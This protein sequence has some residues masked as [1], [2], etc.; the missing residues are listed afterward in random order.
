MTS[1]G[2]IGLLFSLGLGAV[3]AMSCQAPA[4]A[5]AA[6]AKPAP[7]ATPTAQPVPEKKVEAPKPK[8]ARRLLMGS[9][10]TTSSYYAYHVAEG[11]VLNAN[12]PALNVTV[13]ESA[14]GKDN[15]ERM[16]K[17]EIH[18]GLLNGVQAYQAYNGIED[19]KD[20][21]RPDLRYLW[22]YS[23]GARAY[24]VRED[25]GVKTLQ[26]LEG[27]PFNPGLLGSGVD[28]ETKLAF[29]VLGIKPKWYEGRD[30]DTVTAIKNREIVGYVK[31]QAA[32]K[33][34]A[35]TMDLKTFTP[36]RV[37][38]FTPEQVNK[39]KEK[40]PYMSFIKIEAGR[41]YA[42]S[43]EWTGSVVAVGTG[44]MKGVFSDEEAYAMFK[45]VDKNVEQM[46]VAFPAV[47][48]EDYGKLTV[49]TSPIPLHPGS[50]KYLR[51]RGLTVK[52]EL[53]PPEAK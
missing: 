27:K 47:K 36:I 4:A 24:I 3:V 1:K 16:N 30:E 23:W 15:I 40:Y 13:I 43:P 12:V 49:E 25:S 17:A 41:T 22:L 50:I 9:T 19:W 53:I 18:F 31:S 10:S 48:G 7:A 5:P 14:G 34:D 20:K 28:R 42:G 37:L 46:A 52:A 51:E 35:S 6:T 2:W 33:L 29:E 21:R 39:V 45:A 26:D 32:G 8:E 11:R 38:S 44:T